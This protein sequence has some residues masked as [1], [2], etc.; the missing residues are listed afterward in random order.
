MGGIAGGL[1]Y[2]ISRKL[3]F[4]TMQ[5]TL[6]LLKSGVDFDELRFLV[7]SPAGTTIAGLEVLES[8]GIRG[9][10]IQ[11]IKIASQRASELGVESD[12]VE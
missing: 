12:K 3:A 10:I 7:S 4:E 9:S 6:E 8:Q 2:D 1:S 11:S 5:G